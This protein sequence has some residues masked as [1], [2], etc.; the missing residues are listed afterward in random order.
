MYII[1]VL[2]NSI[3]MPFGFSGKKTKTVVKDEKTALKHFF[4][5]KHIYRTVKDDLT[6]RSRTRA[7]SRSRSSRHSVNSWRHFKSALQNS[8]VD[9]LNSYL[10]QFSYEDMF[11]AYVADVKLI[12]ISRVKYFLED[13][14]EVPF[15]ST[16]WTDFQYARKSTYKVH[17]FLQ[18]SDLL[19]QEYE[20]WR[21][22]PKNFRISEEMIAK[23]DVSLPKRPPT[24]RWTPPPPIY[25]PPRFTPLPRHYFRPM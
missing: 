2:Y 13:V 19:R 17:E 21:K 11:R 4:N 18:N 25:T 22:Y 5:Q 15:D 12:R 10:K 14:L 3:S 7:V 20:A 6:S 16:I 8:D 9:A 1:T 24:P 23:I